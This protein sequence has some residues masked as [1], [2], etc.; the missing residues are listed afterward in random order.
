MKNQPPWSLVGLWVGAWVLLCVHLSVT[1][2]N[3]PAYGYGL[4]VPPLC[5]GLLWQRRGEIAEACRHARPLSTSPT[6][7][8]PLLFIG[9]LILLPIELLRMVSPE[10]R[11]IGILGTLA[12]F[13]LTGWILRR[14]GLR[15]I[16][17]AILGAGALFLT[18][19]PWPSALESVITQGLMRQVA[20]STADVLN[21]IGIL[22]IPRGN[23][24]ELKTG[25]V[26]VDEACSGVRSLQSCFM[27]AVALALFFRL[28]MLRMFGLIIASGVLAWIGNL[29][30]TFTLT[31]IAAWKGP[32]A[33]HRFHDPAGVSILIG[34]TF[35]LYLLA[36]RME[37]T[38]KSDRKKPEETREPSLQ[39]ILKLLDWNRLPPV[40]G[41]L[42]MGLTSVVA[43]QLWFLGHDWVSQ[44]QVEPLMTVNENSSL[45]FR[46]EEVPGSIL[47]VLKPEY[48][49][50]F[51][52]YSPKLGDVAVYSFF[53][54][55]GGD[56]LV[57]FFHRPDVCMT[58]AGW[59]MMGEAG[60][61]EVSINGRKT[62][63]YVFHFVRGNQ[64]V[65]QAWG[66]WRDGMEQELNFERGWKH[67]LGQQSQRWTWIR[68]G[69]RNASTEIL[70]VQLDDPSADDEALRCA[71]EETFAM[72]RRDSK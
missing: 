59:E 17:L 25:L 69:R 35:S 47:E 23:L 64:R 24:V 70:S 68:N 33:L 3:N 26:S 32:E 7:G 10:L 31:Y 8:R 54:K 1:W 19:I 53:W 58:G 4:F 66:V 44:P 36:H 50:Y 38:Q 57:G 51:H 61:I 30:R 14:L 48:G 60:R 56:A 67:L 27:A 37:K 18:S 15:P 20:G 9:T 52:G 34:V 62:R 5:L 29:A 63:W 12:C 11:S 22:A 42:A 21:L 65:T 40:R 16:P 72:D 39:E 6:L 49:A 71:I 28:S 13:G 41:V 55:P 43:A 45:H 2:W 46:K